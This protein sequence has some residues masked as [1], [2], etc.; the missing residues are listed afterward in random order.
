MSAKDVLV[1]LFARKTK[2]GSQY[3]YGEAHQRQIQRLGWHASQAYHASQAQKGRDLQYE[4]DE[5]RVEVKNGWDKRHRRYVTDILIYPRDGSGDR[6]HVVID[7]AGNELL[8]EY[9]P[10]K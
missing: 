4:D 6:Y 5:V 2:A 7:E 3:L 1:W 10:G 9:H 8:N